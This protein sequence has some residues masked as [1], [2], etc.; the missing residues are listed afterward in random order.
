MYSN[1]STIWFVKIGHYSHW[2]FPG[3]VYLVVS[4]KYKSVKGY[5]FKYLKTNISF[6][7]GSGKTIEDSN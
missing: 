7:D 1:V 4:D 6:Q 3:S 5:V 2:S